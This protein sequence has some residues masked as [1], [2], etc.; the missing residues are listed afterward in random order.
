MRESIIEQ[1][2]DTV[3][4]DEKLG[5]LNFLMSQVKEPFFKTL[6]NSAQGSP[7]LF[8]G[9]AVVVNSHLNLKLFAN[10]EKMFLDLE[11]QLL[12]D[13]VHVLDDCLTTDVGTDLPGV[14]SIKGPVGVDF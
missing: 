5:I 8:D 11:H 4:F 7:Y 9:L 3:D 6:L 10:Q 2:F 14:F 13:A 1:L 12:N